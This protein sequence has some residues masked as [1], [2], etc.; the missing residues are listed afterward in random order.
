ML[1]S[2]RMMQQCGN[3]SF[4]P[5]VELRH[6]CDGNKNTVVKSAIIVRDR[7]FQ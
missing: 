2:Q 3:V 6:R 5:L 4:S 7:V 1:P